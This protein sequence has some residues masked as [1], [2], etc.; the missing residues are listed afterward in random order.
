MA[1]EHLPAF[2]IA[3]GI[4]QQGWSIEST[5][6]AMPVPDDIRAMWWI[7]P[8]AIQLPIGP[9]LLEPRR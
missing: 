1:D 6:R 3:I 9:S 5:T 4:W 8:H 2:E 7:I